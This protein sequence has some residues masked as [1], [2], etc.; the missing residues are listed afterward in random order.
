MSREQIHGDCTVFYRFSWALTASFPFSIRPGKLGINFL[1]RPAQFSKVKFPGYAALSNPTRA[2]I[3]RPSLLSGSQLGEIK[4]LTLLQ[5]IPSAALLLSDH[6][7]K[8]VVS[9]ERE[10]N[11]EKKGYRHKGCC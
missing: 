8:M 6:L 2:L 11:D 9:S 1:A 10:A 5:A 3:A 4:D 7:S